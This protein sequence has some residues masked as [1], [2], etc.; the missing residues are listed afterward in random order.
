MRDVGVPREE[1]GEIIETVKHEV[2]NA[3]TVGRPVTADE[4]MAIA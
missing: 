3:A 4:L 1:I 2:D